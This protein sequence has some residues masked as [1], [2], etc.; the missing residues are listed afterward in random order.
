M[1]ERLRRELGLKHAIR[2]CA[3]SEQEKV[4][5]AAKRL[6]QHQEHFKAAGINLQGDCVAALRTDQTCL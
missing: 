6:L 5:N 2:V 3:A 4:V 1:L